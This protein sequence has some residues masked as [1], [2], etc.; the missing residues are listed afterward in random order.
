MY[1]YRHAEMICFLGHFL[2]GSGLGNIR[3]FCQ[4]CRCYARNVST[5]I[6]ESVNPGR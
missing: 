1:G 5:G 6:S 4:R 3:F 2:S